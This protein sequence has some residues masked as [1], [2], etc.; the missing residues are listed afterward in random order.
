MRQFII[1]GH[2]APTSPDFSLD[3]LTGGAGRLD[4]LCRCVTA[5]FLLSHGIRD[6]VRVHLVLQDE[7]TVT[8]EG[9][10]L[11]RLNPDERSTAALIRAALAARDEAIGAMAANPSP[12]VYLIRKGLRGVI[13]SLDA[14]SPLI[15]LHEDAEALIETDPP[16]NPAFVLSDHREFTADEADTIEDAADGRVRLGPKRLH[17]DQAIT[18]AHNYLDTDGFSRY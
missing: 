8:F 11:R 9:E 2:D 17:A 13:D 10:E 18:V 3:D 5:A 7:V 15:L 12:G 14:Q 1:V 4:V 6:E 16:A